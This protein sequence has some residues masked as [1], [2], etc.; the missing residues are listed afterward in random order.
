LE[1]KK[2]I[3]TGTIIRTVVLALAL[4]NQILT[5]TGHS[6]IPIDDD[7]V[8]ELLSLLITVITSVIAWWKNNSFTQNAI[9]ADEVLQEL[10]EK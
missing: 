8:T 6:P 7:T 1:E 3:S 10:R 4:I 5:S 9:L 2:K